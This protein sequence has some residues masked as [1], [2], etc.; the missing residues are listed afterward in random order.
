MASP[1]GVS[2]DPV[3][4]DLQRLIAE[5]GWAIRKV[6]PLVGETG[7]PFAYTVGLTAMGHPEIV[8]DGLPGDVAQAFL[9]DVGGQVRDGRPF[10]PGEVTTDLTEN[11]G[12][13]A[14]LEVEDKTHLTAVEQVYGSVSALQPVWSDTRGHLPWHDSYAL[15]ADRQALLGS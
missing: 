1:L 13:M 7:R 11:G 14:F 2:D 8:V 3:L 4:D 10:A 15:P 9:N 5:F 12:P 6:Q